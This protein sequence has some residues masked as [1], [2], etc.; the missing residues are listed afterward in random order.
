MFVLEVTA[1][2][3]IFP[4]FGVHSLHQYTYHKEYCTQVK[5][6]FWE[7][8]IE[9]GIAMTVTVISTVI[10]RLFPAYI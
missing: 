10:L 7:V 4:L 5:L 8:M 9:S 1:S 6:F 3:L 2:Y